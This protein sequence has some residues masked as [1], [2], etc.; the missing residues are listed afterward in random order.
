[1]VRALSSRMMGDHIDRDH[2]EFMGQLIDGYQAGTSDSG[3]NAGTCQGSVVSGI[4]RCA[5][6]TNSTSI[7][8]IIAARQNGLTAGDGRQGI[9]YGAQIKPINLFDSSTS[10]RHVVGDKLKAAIEQASGTEIAVL[11]YGFIDNN[12]DTFT[13]TDDGLDYTFNT[14]YQISTILPKERAAWIEA[15][16]TTVVVVPHGDNGHNNVN[17]IARVVYLA[18][19]PEC[20]IKR[21]SLGSYL[22]P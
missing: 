13:D 2:P 6:S 8:G 18:G 4:G 22:R 19:D 9:A 10:T 12:T 20:S 17:G 1:M 15:V 5:L 3:S 16:K 14:I 21:Y 7:A 11:N